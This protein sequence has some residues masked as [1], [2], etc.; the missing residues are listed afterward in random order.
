MTEQLV[1]REDRGAVAVLRLNRPQAHNALN[2]GVMEALT[3]ALAGCLDDDAVRAVVLTGSE[4]VFCAGAD[5]TAFDA[6]RAEPLLGSFDAAG[7][8]MWA[9]LD[10]FGKPLIAAVEGVAF[11]GG[12]ELALA[13]DTVI[14]GARARFAVPEV[15]L[16]VIP[17]AGGTQR[18]I[19]AIGK[20]KAMAMLLSGDPLDAAAADRAGLVASVVEDGQALAAAL[21]L[22]ERIAANSPL[23]VALAKDAALASLETSLSQGLRHER[24]NFHVALQSADCREGQ[25]AFLDKRTPQFQGR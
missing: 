10:T 15:G 25:S 6:L 13:C 22:A 21:A 4:R 7:G 3:A 18:L 17:G 2:R 12:C 20:A 16:G 24:A 9:M 11:G 14:A 5:I 19:T 8:P 1:T 23:A